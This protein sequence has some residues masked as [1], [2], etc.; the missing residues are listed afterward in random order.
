MW[1]ERHQKKAS[2]IK[3]LVDLNG[4]TLIVR[5]ARQ[6]GKTSFI[7]NALQDLP[8]YPQIKLNFMYPGSFRLNGV[9]YLGRDFFGK[10]ETGEEFLK[11]LETEFG[12]ASLP[13]VVFIDEADRYPLSL[14]SVQTLSQFTDKFKFVITGSNLENIVVKNA[15]TGRKKYFDLFPVTFAEF[16]CAGGHDKLPGLLNQISLERSDSISEFHHK[17][18]NELFKIY[19]RIGGMP[20]VVAACLGSPDEKNAIPEIIKDLAVSIEENVKTVLGEKSKLYEYE[21]V[22]RKL[23]QCSMNTLKYSHLQ[24]QH[25]GRSEAKKLVAK[26]VGAR[27]SHKIRLLESER[28]LS[29]Y[30]IFDCGIAN[31]LLCGS[32]LLKN[33]INDRDLAILCETFVGNELISGLTIRDDL[34]YWKSEN[35]AEVEFILRSPSVGI[36]VK[37][38]KGNAKSLNS[39]AIF[40]PSIEYLVKICDSLP[41]LDPEYSAYLPG[42]GEKRKLPLIT[43]PHYLAGRLV[44]LV[45]NLHIKNQTD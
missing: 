40:E 2:F 35:R 9:D 41:N 7:L 31:Y 20:R 43:L 14:E 8:Q 18:L 24:V 30:M 26:T 29:K 25:A 13:S 33:R 22:L 5:G 27:V 39:L 44:E 34:L 16:V 36:D 19:L 38:R 32:D 12:S 10:S 37:A 28:D 15:A 21:D 11:N 45:K 17:Q 6:V 4:Q 23:A 42:A 3:S 1:I